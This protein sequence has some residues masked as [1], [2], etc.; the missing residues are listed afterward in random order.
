M[1]PAGVGVEGAGHGS[2]DDLIVAVGQSDHVG[3]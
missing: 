2:V 3:L 1:V